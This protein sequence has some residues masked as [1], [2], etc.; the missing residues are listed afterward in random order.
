MATF[1]PASY[2]WLEDEVSLDH[3]KI[4]FVHSHSNYDI[5]VGGEIYSMQ[6][7]NSIQES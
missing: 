5:F 4:R 6:S 7:L 3:N 2:V 1:A